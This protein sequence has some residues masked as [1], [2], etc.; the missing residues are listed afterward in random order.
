MGKTIF[1]KKP[2]LGKEVSGLLKNESIK[3]VAAI[4]LVLEKYFTER[5]YGK[6]KDIHEFT[7]VCSLS[8]LPMAKEMEK[9]FMLTI[10]GGSISNK[11]GNIMANKNS[12]LASLFF[13]SFL[14]EGLIISFESYLTFY[15]QHANPAADGKKMLNKR[16]SN[17][18]SFTL[19]YRSES[20][21]IIEKLSRTKVWLWCTK[22]KTT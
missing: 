22:I 3:N 11:D 18:I 12:E 6:T 8:I 14:G 10:E 13:K 19:R 7:P 9:D 5:I 4:M 21:P 16:Q 15:N 17:S 2:L 20:E 1:Q